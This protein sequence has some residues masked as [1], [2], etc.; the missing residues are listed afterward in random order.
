M[1]SA[2]HMGPVAI[3]RGLKRYRHWILDHHVDY[4]G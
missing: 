3:G 2:F 1:I 4:Y